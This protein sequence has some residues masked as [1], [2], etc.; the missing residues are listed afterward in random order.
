[1]SGRSLI[2]PMSVSMDGF[3]GRPDRTIDCRR[4][5]TKQERAHVDLEASG[6]SIVD[7][8]LYMVLATADADGRPWASPVYFASEDYTELYW[9]SSPE[10]THSRNLAARSELSIVV[11]DSQTPI[12]TGQAVYMSAVAGQVTGAELE[13]SIAIFSSRALAHGGREW[14]VADVSEPA[15]LRLYRA[16]VSAHFM[17]DKSGEGPR[18]DHRTPV[19]LTRAG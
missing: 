6:R 13:R 19:Q 14:T 5:L 10:V 3:A 17:L 12:S 15:P 8:N 9:V 2:L 7:D 18:Y 4:H 11:F 1:M 16:T